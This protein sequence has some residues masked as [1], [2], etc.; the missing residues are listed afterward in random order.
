DTVAKF[1]HEARRNGDSSGGLR[2]GEVV[3]VDEAAMVATT[4]LATLVDVVESAGAKLV[5]A[6]DHRQLG[7]VE[8]GGLFRLLVADSRAA[9]LH[10]VR[11]FV[12]PWEAKAT[13]ALRD[14]DD[15][16]LGDYQAHGRISG[17]T[18]QDMIDDA[19]STWRTARAAGES[20][21]VMAPDHPTV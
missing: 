20:I 1:L 4:D 6:G 8:A 3:V 17:G 18:R 10:D 12:H 13:L 9:Q 7:A 15:S 14:G 21:V 16:V 19:F 11:R 2:P 5:L